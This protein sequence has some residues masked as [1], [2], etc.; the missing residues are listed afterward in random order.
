MSMTNLLG[1]LDR[2]WRNSIY[3]LRESQLPKLLLLEI[4]HYWLEQ[5]TAKLTLLHRIV[6]FLRSWKISGMNLMVMMMVIQF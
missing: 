4:L 3:A 6:L 1:Y 5:V 2:G